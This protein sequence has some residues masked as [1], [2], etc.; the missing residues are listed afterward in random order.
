MQITVKALAKI[1]W[2]LDITKRLENGYHE[3]DMLMQ[4]IDLSDDI[5]LSDARFTSLLIGD[6]PAPNMEKNLV[7]RA[8][9]AIAEYTGEKR[10]VKISLT[11]RIPVRAGLGGGSAD[12]AATL[13]ALN[14][15]WKLRLPVKTMM[16]IGLK[17]GADVPYCVAGGFCRVRGIG[18]KVEAIENAPEKYVVITI[19]GGGLSTQM[20][21]ND[22]DLNQDGPLKIDMPLVQKALTDW[23]V[24]TLRENGANALERAAIRQIPEIANQISE[25]Y[26]YGAQY[27]R[28]SGSGSSV[29]GV[30]DSLEAANEC[31]KMIPGAY[32]SK[33][34]AG[35]SR[36]L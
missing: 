28:M 27:A 21:F 10:N 8:V 20:V 13:I 17:L 9:N 30:F 4:N 5:T 29:Y 2:A 7:Y 11:K 14:E 18:E 23:D 24:R 33:T 35:K 34:I 3:M 6:K 16:E 19:V 25:F 36:I 1:N 32:V 22:F 12:G 15:M 26:R 31:A